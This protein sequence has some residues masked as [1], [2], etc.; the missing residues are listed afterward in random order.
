MIGNTYPNRRR[1]CTAFCRR[2]CAGS[3]NPNTALFR[4]GHA[5]PRGLATKYNPR[6]IATAPT[7]DH[8]NLR[9]LA[10]APTP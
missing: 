5:N 4:P 6:G 7:L 8:S 10:T 1:G 3:T 2:G 9:G